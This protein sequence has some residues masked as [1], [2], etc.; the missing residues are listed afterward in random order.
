MKIWSRFHTATFSRQPINVNSTCKSDVSSF[1][2][3]YIT[4]QEFVRICPR[5]LCTYHELLWLSLARNPALW[6]VSLRPS[7]VHLLHHQQHCS[8][9]RAERWET[10]SKNKC[11][12]LKQQNLKIIDLSDSAP[13]ASCQDCVLEEASSSKDTLEAFCRSDFG[14][15][16]QAS[17]V[18]IH[19]VSFSPS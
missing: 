5:E 4:L 1:F 3:V 11:V 17:R 8:N 15:Y 6:P 14:E 18:V 19:F 16:Q 10:Y 7:H 2:Q 12:H 9:R 13:Q